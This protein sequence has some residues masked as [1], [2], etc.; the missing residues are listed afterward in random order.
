MTFHSNTRDRSEA[1]AHEMYAERRRQVL[2]LGYTPA[3]DDQ[4][5]PAQLLHLAEQQIARLRAAS[6]PATGLNP[7][8]RQ[9]LIK[10]GA[11]LMATAERLDRELP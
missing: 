8:E 5:T 1:V 6:D 7:A 10:A 9:R 4:H 2:D 11:L 3:H